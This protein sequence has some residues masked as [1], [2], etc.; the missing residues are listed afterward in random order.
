[1]NQVEFI[2]AIANYESEDFVT[3]FN[4]LIKSVPKWTIRAKRPEKFIAALMGEA[5][6]FETQD[7][8]VKLDSLIYKHFF[9]IT[10]SDKENERYRE[11]YEVYHDSSLFD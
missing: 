4:R 3:K 10:I 7:F 5:L 11:L 9:D 6:R 2:S 8:V 1:M